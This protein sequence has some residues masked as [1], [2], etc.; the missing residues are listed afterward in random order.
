[1]RTFRTAS[2]L[3]ALAALTAGLWLL[4]EPVAEI[5]N[6]VAREEGSPD[7]GQGIATADGMSA[8]PLEKTFA[9]GTNPGAKPAQPT[10]WSVLRERMRQDG[11]GL[12]EVTHPDGHV[13]INLEG[14]YSHVVTA[15]QD[16]SGTYVIQCFAD[17]DAMKG[18][19]SGTHQRPEIKPPSPPTYEIAEF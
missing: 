5:E 4:R 1:M 13:S 15:V 2:W 18:T 17:F 14:R 9:D 8:Q 16:A 19:L 3:L 10:D 11:Q 12:K 6:P 7:P